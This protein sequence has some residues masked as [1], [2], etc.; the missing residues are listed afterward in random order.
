[1][2]TIYF[3]PKKRADLSVCGEMGKGFSPIVARTSTIGTDDL[4]KH[5]EKRCT[6]TGADVKCVVSALSDCMAEYM[7]NG[8]SIHIDDLGT[9][10]IVLSGPKMN[11]AATDVSRFVK[12]KRVTFRACNRLKDNFDNCKFVQVAVKENDVDDL[13]DE[14]LMVLLRERFD[15]GDGVPFTRCDVQMTTGLSRSK[16]LSLLR[17]MSEQGVLLHRKMGNTPV[18]WF[19][20]QM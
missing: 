9:F 13:S 17:R 20:A 6:L 11:D 7:A 3:K 5:I 16:S 10:G 14:Q 4:I 2:N 18:Y 12:V 19:A 8:F 15:N 1:M